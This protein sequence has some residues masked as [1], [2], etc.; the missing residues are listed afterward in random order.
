MQ[1]FIKK[2]K[3]QRLELVALRRHHP[4][5]LPSTTA[6]TP[7]TPSPAVPGDLASCTEN[8][9][10]DRST[11]HNAWETRLKQLEKKHQKNIEELE[12]ATIWRGSSLTDQ[13]GLFISKVYKSIQALIRSKIW[14]K[15]Y[16]DEV[17][18]SGLKWT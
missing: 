9:D 18:G 1:S 4:R 12:S 2:K 13:N 16:L 6:G 7:P 5:C 3:L 15:M 8:M 11:E 14:S 10:T 17:V